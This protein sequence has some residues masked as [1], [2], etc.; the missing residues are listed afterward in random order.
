MISSII[1]YV[2]S[3]RRL[4]FRY[5]FE[6]G[7]VKEKYSYNINRSLASRAVSIEIEGEPGLPS[8]VVIDMFDIPENIRKVKLRYVKIY[9]VTLS[10]VNLYSLVIEHSE[11]MDGQFFYIGRVHHLR[12]YKSD[13][14][15]FELFYPEQVYTLDIIK[16]GLVKMPVSISRCTFLKSHLSIPYSIVTPKE[17]ER[18]WF[19]IFFSR[20]EEEFDNYFYADL[21]MML[22]K[23]VRENGH[24]TEIMGDLHAD[25]LT[26]VATAIANYQTR[27]STRFPLSQIVRHNISEFIDL[28]DDVFKTIL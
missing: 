8:S 14:D 16:T 26:D 27:F 3:F 2:R 24:E 17:K 5:G 15:S 25:V 9:S 23:H 18:A 21:K 4:T 10:T 11:F 12:I 19:G 22:D 20:A 6:D 28:Y 13:V 1:D 7:S